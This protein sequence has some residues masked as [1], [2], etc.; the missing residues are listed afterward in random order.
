MTVKEFEKWAE[1][2]G[3]ARRPYHSNGIDYEFVTMRDGWTA[4]FERSGGDYLPL[5]QSA[6]EPHAESYCYLREP[7][8][9]PV[10]AI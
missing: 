8:P 2:N 5:I 6:D 9:V 1:E 3:T 7:V 4:V 10:Q